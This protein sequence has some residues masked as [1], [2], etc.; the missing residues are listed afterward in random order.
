LEETSGGPLKLHSARDL[1][2]FVPT[3]RDAGDRS[4]SQYPVSVF[5]S[6]TEDVWLACANDFILGVAFRRLFGH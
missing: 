6:H 2:D 5:V 1:E 4:V 3:S